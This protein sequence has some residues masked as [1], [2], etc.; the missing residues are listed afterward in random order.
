MSGDTSGIELVKARK[1]RPCDWCGEAIERRATYYRWGYFND[2]RA[3]ACRVHPECYA[4]MRNDPDCRDEEWDLHEH[5]RGC[6]CHQSEPCGK[7]REGE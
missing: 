1:D 7:H 3:T 5:T 4:G 6:F 2:G